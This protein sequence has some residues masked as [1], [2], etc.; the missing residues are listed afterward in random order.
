M[1]VKG[2]GRSEV[3]VSGWTKGRGYH[4]VMKR[5]GTEMGDIPGVLPIRW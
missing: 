1:N 3:F 4:G 5:V 2:R